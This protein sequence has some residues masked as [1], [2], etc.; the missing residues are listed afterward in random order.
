MKYIGTFKSIKDLTYKVE[1]V[2]NYD[3][4]VSQEIILGTPP[5]VITLEGGDSTIYKPI[6]YTGATL[7]IATSDILQDLYSPTNQGVSV[8]CY[9]QYPSGIKDYKFKGFV[10]PNIYNQAYSPFPENLEIECVDALS[11]LKNIDYNTVGET[12][13]IVSFFDIYC[14]I[15][16]KT[17][18]IQNLYIS[19]SYETTANTI[20]HYC[21]I[22]E[23]NFFDEDDKPMK[24][25]EVLEEITK[26][27]GM[28][29]VQIGGNAFLFDFDAEPNFKEFNI[30]T[31]E[32]TGTYIGGSNTITQNLFKSSNS[33]LE[34]GEVY[35]KASVE[36]DIY[37]ITGAVIEPLDTKSLTPMSVNNLSEITRVEPHQ[38]IDGKDTYLRRYLYYRLSKSKSLRH[39]Y[40]KLDPLGA[41][42]ILSV[43]IKNWV[44]PDES[45]NT[46]IGATVVQKYVSTNPS[47]CYTGHYEGLDPYVSFRFY[48]EDEINLS[49]SLLLHLHNDI[50][51]NRNSD[52]LRHLFSIR[53]SDKNVILKDKQ[54]VLKCTSKWIVNQPFF[55]ENP[56]SEVEKNCRMK[57]YLPRIPYTVTTTDGKIRK[58]TDI[59]PSYPTGFHTYKIEWLN[60]DEVELKDCVDYVEFFVEYEDD[61]KEK[62]GKLDQLSPEELTN[63]R[64]N[65][66]RK[67]FANETLKL[68]IP[69]MFRITSDGKDETA[70]T[71]LVNIT[72][73][74]GLP[75]V[76][77]EGMNLADIQINF[78]QPINP[79]E[80][81]EKYK[82][83]GI[84][85]DNFEL[86]LKNLSESTIDDTE[87]DN[88]NTR[89]ENVI[90]DDYLIKMDNVT[91]K[92]CTYD[93]K[94]PTFSSVYY[95]DDNG[96]FKF[97]NTL[98]HKN[99]P[100]ELCS[101]ELMIY[102]LVN[103]HKMPSTILNVDIT[104][105][106]QPSYYQYVYP[107]QFGSK[108]FIYDS[109]TTDFEADT[110]SLR[111]VEKF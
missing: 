40:Y 70:D 105:Q 73:V 100:D 10:T 52:V 54:L 104:T 18:T 63:L 82:L 49:T 109:F 86:S 29:L 8:C 2:T 66:L 33:N 42:P 60:Q 59:A 30:V 65:M 41:V 88:T 111:L 89:Y 74:D 101:E 48:P 71:E 3:E 91:F 110:T 38:V 45:L 79:S 96:D 36:D 5:F 24:C 21:H 20:A 87:K 16:K 58:I 11:T 27:C 53:P 106:H 44:E 15:L 94:E 85:L 17:N 35:N 46:Y 1:I 39:S 78:Y 50:T 68:S 34:L 25:D 37:S 103:Q 72:P 102:R 83:N 107:T 97:I 95:K 67:N 84:W 55:I 93:G 57:H 23:S 4:S 32:Q 22:S 80:E 56:D 43:N 90:D 28:T 31:G 77:L 76:G 51:K 9:W 7:R 19:D 62:L 14:H 108:K 75:I 12:K 98:K 47:Y 64:E 6:K 13:N 61:V 99:I 26:F 92:V 69:N 81:P